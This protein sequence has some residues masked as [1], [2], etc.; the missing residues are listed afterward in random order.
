M[1]MCPAIQRDHRRGVATL[2]LG[3]G[4]GGDGD[5]HGGAVLGQDQKIARTG[6]KKAEA[7]AAWL[8]LDLARQ[9]CYTCTVSDAW[10]LWDRVMREWSDPNAIA[11]DTYAPLTLEF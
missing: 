11:H 2:R 5:D 6:R 8:T 1:V 9:T 3:C 10:Q 7:H 4:R